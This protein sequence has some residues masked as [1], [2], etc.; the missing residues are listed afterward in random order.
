MQGISEAIETA[1]LHYRSG[2]F[3]E[4]EAVCRR[5]LAQNPNHAESFHLLGVSAFQSG[6]LASAVEYLEKACGLE[7]NNA[8]YWNNLGVVYQEQRNY[9]QALIC[10]E[11]ASQADPH[12][13]NAWHNWGMLFQR[14]GR[15]E[16]AID[17]FQ[18][19]IASNPNEVVFYNTMG[20]IYQLKGQPTESISWYQQAI[21]RNPNYAEAHSNLGFALQ[22]VGRL[23]EAQVACQQAL[24]LNPN[25]IE[26]H[27]NLGNIYKLKGMSED[28]CQS[29]EKALALNPNYA[30]AHNNLGSVFETLRNLEK[31]ISHY[32]EAL[33]LKPDFADAYQN[34]G[35]A[36]LDSG[37]SEAGLK[38]YEKAMAIQPSEGLRFKIATALPRIYQSI[39]DLDAWR[40]RFIAGLRSLQENPLHLVNPVTEI[41]TVNFYLTYQGYPNKTLQQDVARLFMPPKREQT[42]P[43]PI[44]TQKPKIGFV[45]RYFLKPHTLGKVF[46]G[47]LEHFSREQFDVVILTIDAQE[48][49]PVGAPH[50]H[51]NLPGLQL[52]KARQL[53]VDQQLDIL[54]YTDIGMEPLTYFLAQERLAHVQCV[55]WGHPDTTGIDTIDYYLSSKLFETENSQADYS[56]KLICL[57]TIPTYYSR[58]KLGE[59]I[60][61]RQD[62]GFE[63][64]DHL[65]LC[66]QTFFKFHPA[67]D[68]LLGGILQ[69]DPK[70]KLVLANALHEAWNEKILHRFRS[71]FSPEVMAQIVILDRMEYNAFLYLLT[72][73]DV[74]LDTLHFGGGSTTYEAL[75]LGTP[76]V[77]W[78]SEL[79]R[80]RMAYGCYQKMNV[81]DCVASSAQEYIE[82]SVKLGT[83][84]TYRTEIK[85]KILS[86]NAVLYEDI[87]AVRE[88]E[89]FLLRALKSVGKK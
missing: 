51:I 45:S 75:S 46:L 32:H 1:L 14:L 84:S 53:I 30:E 5:I 36:L 16:E 73:G 26:A 4:L 39:E 68:E 70:G 78:P 79:M 65:Y 47:V 57:E 82:I 54:F 24:S 52:E 66:P 61:T 86:A 33:R 11:K 25:S 69:R 43:Y 56:E 81:L 83:D 62:F 44:N 60:Y 41:G 34:L 87:A 74:M 3:Q 85:E 37:E 2:Q 64:A 15:L 28:A 50:T 88:I 12:F 49:P 31:A 8:N 21:Q 6:Q 13:T 48:P 23:D 7:K 72:L 67:F 77:T 59:K 89:T 35:G 71:R 58:P 9:P 17:V 27:N 76:V 42:C 80:G 38:A 18:Q 55:T 22:I 29:Y 40:E 63:E 20:V 10:F 19:A